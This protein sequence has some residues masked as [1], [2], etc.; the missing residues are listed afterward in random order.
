[1]SLICHTKIKKAILKVVYFQGEELEV[2]VGTSVTI[3]LRH[4]S[5]EYSQISY[6]SKVID[7]NETELI[8]DYPV[9]P[10]EY[11]QLPIRPDHTVDIEY[12]TKGS[13]Y[14]F[15][16]NVIRVIDSPIVSFV[17]DMPDE[18][19]I[20]K[21]QRREY[22]RINIDVNVAVHSEKELF[23]PF[24]SVTHDISGGGLAI[25]TPKN[26]T[27]TEG[28]IVDLYLVLKSKYSDF[29][30][31]KTK[32][33][34]IRTTVFNEVRSTSLRFQFDDERDRQKIIKYCFEIQREKLKR[35]IL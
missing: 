20:T 16:A 12:V 34:I 23:T 27:L 29:V 22:V 33:E 1:M 6:R 11:L 17:V 3:T 4:H 24:I 35:Q 9:E 18:K 7:R 30:Y 25:I 5:N 10:D 26:V 32:G 2:K 21:I 19:N 31:L 8:I 13:V 28:E 14:K 15:P